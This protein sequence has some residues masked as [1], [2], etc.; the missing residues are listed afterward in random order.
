ML[1]YVAYLFS[2]DVHMHY[3]FNT[4]TSKCHDENL[5]LAF[6]VAYWHII[7]IVHVE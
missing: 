4:Y 5:E 6:Q 1:K 7:H 3:F 2:I